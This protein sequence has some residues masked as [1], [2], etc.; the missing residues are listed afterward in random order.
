MA[1]LDPLG[2]NS[3]VELAVIAGLDPAIQEPSIVERAQFVERLS[4]L[5][6]RV[7]PGHDRPAILNGLLSWIFLLFAESFF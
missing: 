2:A 7:K 3:S 1:G 4:R 6:G 5:D